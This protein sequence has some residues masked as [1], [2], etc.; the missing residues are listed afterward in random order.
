MYAIAFDL[1]VD[2]ANALHPKGQRTAYDDIGR[3]MRRHGFRWVQGSLYVTDRSLEAVTFVMVDLRAL[4]WF[5]QAVRDIRAFKVESWS[6]FTT[7]FKEPS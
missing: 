2:V 1:I 5:P 6:D 7:F 4:P 3:V